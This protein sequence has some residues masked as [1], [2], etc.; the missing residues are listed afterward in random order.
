MGSEASILFVSTK[1][2][3][4]TFDIVPA[5]QL[6]KQG[7]LQLDDIVLI[8]LLWRVVYNLINSNSLRSQRSAIP[9]RN[10]ETQSSVPNDRQ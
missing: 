10:G 6:I 5:E 2:A 4:L 7:G 9:L 3:S 8:S 1:L